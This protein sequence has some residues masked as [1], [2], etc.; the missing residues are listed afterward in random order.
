M[1]VIMTP[2]KELELTKMRESIQEWKK[3]IEENNLINKQL[4][5]MIENMER[6]IQKMENESNVNIY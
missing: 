5:T 6:A 2:R 1:G 4:Q 3:T